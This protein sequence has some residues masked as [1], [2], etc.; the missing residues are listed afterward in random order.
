M[1][2]NPTA[3]APILSFPPKTN[4]FFVIPN[5]YEARSPKFK[6]KIIILTQLDQIS[7]FT[8]KRDYDVP[9]APRR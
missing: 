4:L 1:I 2:G 3:K 8:Y 6:L 9:N 7:V 5:K